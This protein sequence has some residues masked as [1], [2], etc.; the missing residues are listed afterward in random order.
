MIQVDAP[1]KFATLHDEH[2]RRSGGDD[3]PRSSLNVN[4]PLREAAALDP[5]LGVAPAGG[6]LRGI[7]FGAALWA[8]ALIAYEVWVLR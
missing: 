4:P 5:D 6:M 8:L 2:A 1:R 7:V 3:A